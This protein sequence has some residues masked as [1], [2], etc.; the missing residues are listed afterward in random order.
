MNALPAVIDTTKFSDATAEKVVLAYLLQNQK[1]DDI[2]SS[3][4]DISFSEEFHQIL[5]RVCR[6]YSTGTGRGCVDFPAVCDEI[7]RAYPVK[8]NDDAKEYVGELHTRNLGECPALEY[9]LKRL[10]ELQIRRQYIRSMWNNLKAA[11]DE[12]EDIHAILN[13]TDEDI[14]QIEGVGH[15]KVEIVF[16]DEIMRRRLLGLQERYGREPIYTFWEDFDKHLSGGFIPGKLT[17]VAGRTSMGKSLFKTNLITSMGPHGVGIM[18][19]CPEQGFDSEHDRIDAVQSGVALRDII[20]IREMAEDD[21]RISYLKESSE[22]VSSWNY[23]CVPSRNITVAGISMAIRRAKRRG[24]TP[25]VVFVDLFD[26]LADV[27]V[28]KEKTPTIG[29]KLK[30][31]MRIADEEHV[32]LILLVQVSRKTEDRRDNRP[33]MSDLKDC[34]NFEQDADNV[35]LLYREGYYNQDVEDNVLDVNIAKQRDGVRNIVYQFAILDQKTLAIAPIGKKEFIM[36]E[37]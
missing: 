25:Q 31:V 12:R 29:A 13:R 18:N 24:N 30:Q 15:K 23:T 36:K 27:A 17:I 6:D 21:P 32:H 26:S 33:T 19:I 7:S 11:Q 3:C 22:R 20:R 8:F 28:A 16:P 37:K 34:G 35:F 1:I 4:T 2:T 10:E 5:F 9:V 14:G